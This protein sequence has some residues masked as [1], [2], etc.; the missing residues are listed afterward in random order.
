MIKSEFIS[1]DMS[2]NKNAINLTGHQQS[3]F[4]KMVEFVNSPDRRVFI[5]RGYAGTGK[6]TMMR[7]FID[8]LNKTNVHY[9][10][11]ASTGR[12]AKILN[13]ATG[14]D[15]TTIHGLIYKFKDINENL[16]DIVKKREEVGV[17][18][19]GQ[20]FLKFDLAPVE[21]KNEEICYIVDEA[22]MV[23]DNLDKQSSQAVFGTG[24]LLSDL[25]DYDPNGK[26]IFVGDSCQLPPVNQKMSPALNVDYFKT[27]F[28]INARE[29]ELTEVLRQSSGNDIVHSAKKMRQLYYNPQPWKWAKFPMKGYNNIKILPSQARLMELYVRDVKE[30]G[31]NEATM[32]CYSNSQSNTLTNI[33]RPQ[34]GKL[35]TILQVGDLLLVTQNNLISGL[36]NGDLV[37]VNEIA[38]R[39]VRA[40]LTF[41]KVSMKELS[42]NKCYSQYLIEEILYHNATNLT[43]E[44]Q[45]DLY[46][47]FF[48]RMK[49]KGIKQGTKAFEDM[50]RK[51]SYL[52]ALRAVFGYALTCHKSQGGEWERV[53]LDIPR[54]LPLV[55]K[56]YVYQW[57]YT[58][59]T[60]ARQ[61]LY[62]VDDFWIM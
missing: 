44:Q 23:S 39:V 3:A 27:A 10:L 41:L 21:N 28:H 19:T 29:C 55:E 25:L 56:P 30:H 60:R 18:S 54:N 2:E 24:K 14:C 1:S 37:V 45:T 7:V 35:G 20:L 58:A 59:M 48:I 46:I 11:L 17:D 62:I 33:I 26:F 6:T 51:D 34:F 13:N 52:N 57:M 61:E 40:G 16:E 12:A 43:Q 53:Y 22:S 9:R 4:D 5:L 49:N 32:L 38:E 47:D 8:H 31:F 50:M 42:S 36:L 15:A